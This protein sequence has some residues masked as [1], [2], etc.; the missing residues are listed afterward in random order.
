MTRHSLTR[1]SIA[2]IG[3]GSNL[4]QPVQQIERALLALDQLPNSYLLSYSSL[5][6]SAPMGP[7]DQP[8]FINAVAKLATGFTPIELLD[9][10]QAI[11]NQ[12][13]RVREERWGARTLDLD[14]L[15]YDHTIMQTD[16]LTLPHYGIKDRDFVL[17]PLVELSP[18]MSLPDGSLI[19]DLLEK[20]PQY[21]LVALTYDKNHHWHLC[22]DAAETDDSEPGVIE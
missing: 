9:Q 3:L 13:G 4:A 5:Y 12:Q 10:L 17:K 1:R 21:D 18:E 2:Y 15:L 19:K 22:K 8:P 14:L 16:R 11:E 20:C 7:Q 6:Q